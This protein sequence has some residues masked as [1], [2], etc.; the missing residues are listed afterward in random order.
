MKDY[1]KVLGVSKSASKDEIKKAFY[2]LAHQH[3]PD[4]N[5]GDD[6]K[7][8]EVN[9]AYQVLSDEKKRAHFDQFGTNPGANITNKKYPPY[10]IFL[11]FQTFCLLIISVSINLTKLGLIISAF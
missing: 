9:E 7:F 10:D 11:F 1:Y 3:H 4:K 6:K 5:K 8:K 2:K